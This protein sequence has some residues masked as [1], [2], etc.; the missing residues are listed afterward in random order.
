MTANPVHSHELYLVRHG[1][2]AW[3]KERRMQ[4]RKN[5]PLNAQG[6]DQARQVGAL[7]ARIIG[8]IEDF[9][10]MTS[11]LGRT[12]QTAEIIGNAI[13]RSVDEIVH[14]DL[15]QELS[16]GEWEGHVFRDIQAKWPDHVERWRG[17]HWNVGPPGG[18]SYEA[19]HARAVKWFTTLAPG[20]KAIIV[21]H[22][23]MGRL[24]RGAY[25]NLPRAEILTLDLPQ[26]AV[27]RLR[28]GQIERI[29]AG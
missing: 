11:P 6:E 19:A 4:G 28:N 24:I 20:T 7:L 22:G 13:G 10:L 8:N 14:D 3:N 18:E 29:E 12:R 16:W 17:D 23:G 2:T 27:F 21:S 1:E 9:A 26:D 15:I 5:S 25:A